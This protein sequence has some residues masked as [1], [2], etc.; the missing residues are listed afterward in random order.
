MIA[1]C[2]FRL[3]NPPI[4]LRSLSRLSPSLSST[5]RPRPRPFFSSASGGCSA[6]RAPIAKC[7]Q[8]GR[9]VGVC[10]PRPRLGLWAILRGCSLVRWRRGSGA[11]AGGPLWCSRRTRQTTFVSKLVSQDLVWNSRTATDGRVDADVVDGGEIALASLARPSSS[12]CTAATPLGT[13][14]PPPPPFNVGSVL[15]LQVRCVVSRRRSEGAGKDGPV[16]TLPSSPATKREGESCDSPSKEFKCKEAPRFHAHFGLFYDRQGD[17]YFPKCGHYGLPA[18]VHSILCIASVAF[19]FA[20]GF[21]R[22]PNSGRKLL[23]SLAQCALLPEIRGGHVRPAPSL[24]LGKLKTFCLVRSHICRPSLDSK[25][26]D[27]G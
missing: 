9:E 3:A 22:L 14:A 1:H 8:E 26:S 18:N 15:L 25:P 6:L 2:I 4:L 10:G 16:L 24:G 21:R 17:D 23:A 19:L 13:T 12:I 11:G 5:L 20:A 7:A 27:R